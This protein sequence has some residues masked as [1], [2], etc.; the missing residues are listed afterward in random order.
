MARPVAWGDRGVRRAAAGRA[1]HPGGQ[2]RRGRHAAGPRRLPVRAD[3]L[4]RAPQGRGRQPDRLV[5]GPRHDGRDL[6]GARGGRD[7]R[8]LRVDRQHQRLRRGVR[9]QGR[10]V[11]RRARP[12]RPDR[13]RASSPRPWC[14]AP[15]CCRSRAAST[16][17]C[18]WPAAWP[19]SC[20]WPW[21]TRVNAYRIEGQKTAAFEIVDTL[22]RAPDVHC[23]PVG[24]AGNITAYWKGYLEYAGDG[25]SR[26]A[27]DVGLPGRGR[28]ADRAGPPG[29]LAGHHGDRHPDRQPRVVDRRGRGPGRVRRPDRGGDRP[30]RSWTR[31]GCS[32]PTRG[33]SSSRPAPPRW[34]ACCS[35]TA[36][37]CSTPGLLV[38][39]TVTGNGLKDTETALREITIDTQTVPADVRAAAAALGLQPA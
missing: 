10:A 35:R 36:G 25:R 21:S 16:T 1:G 22:G 13:R 7:R 15:G 30:R 19:T 20:R 11:L 34:P 37:G 23:L 14:T 18:G 26:P 32:R 33:C 4:R 6:Q 3:R 39:C 31:S 9:R 8:H 12:A 17:A 2:P 29:R 24:N 27:P 5:Q 38:V 28:R